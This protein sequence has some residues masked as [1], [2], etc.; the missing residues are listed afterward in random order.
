MHYYDA[1]E[2]SLVKCVEWLKTKLK[3]MMLKK[4]GN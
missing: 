3:R 1:K 4:V 2:S